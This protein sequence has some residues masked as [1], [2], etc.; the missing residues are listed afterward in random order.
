MKCTNSGSS[1][2]RSVAKIRR[3]RRERVPLVE[4]MEDWN[5]DIVEDEVVPLKKKTCTRYKYDPVQ[6]WNW[7]FSSK[8]RRSPRGVCWNIQMAR[9]LQEIL[10]KESDLVWEI[11][12]YISGWCVGRKNEPPQETKYHVVTCDDDHIELSGLQEISFD[13]WLENAR[14]N[15]DLKYKGFVWT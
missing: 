11:K 2:F 3:K 9:C 8:T 1:L 10:K 4:T 15:L 13:E 7:F 14:A 6:Q 5:M 12:F